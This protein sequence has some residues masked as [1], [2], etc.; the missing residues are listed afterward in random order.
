MRSVALLGRPGAALLTCTV[1]ITTVL[2]LA[3]GGVASAAVRAAPADVAPGAPGAPSYFDLARKDCVGTATGTRSRV[4]YTVA[5]GVLSDV[6]EPTI[7][8]TDVSTLQY[9]VTDGATFTDLQA[10]DMTYT[11]A[12]D[13]TGMACT[14][15]ATDAGHGFR[16]ITTYITDPARDTV[17]MRTRLAALRGSGTNLADLHLYARLDAHV[18]GN[19]GGGSQNAGGN[20]GGIDTSTGSPVP[21]ISSTNTVTNAVNRDYAV[22]TFMALDASVSSPA[23]SVGY[24]GSASDGLTQL[25][26]DRAL[27]PYDSAPDGHVTAT[28]EVTPGRGHSVT[29]AL[30]FGRDQASAVATARRSL[31]QPFATAELNYLHGWLGYDAGLR[32]PFGD[33]GAAAWRD[34]GAI[35]HY[36]LS[37]NVIKA[38][39]DKTYPGAIVASL[40]SPWGQSVPAGNF[41][42]G[43][44]GYFGSYREVFARDLYEAFTGLLVDGDLVTARAATRFLFDRQQQ[45]D[46]SMPRNSLLNGKTAPDTGG[47]QLDET[48]YPIVMALQAGLGGNGALWRDHIRPAADFLVAHGPS[49]GVERW[50]EQS[51]YSPSTIAAEI[52]GL[53]AASVIAGEHHD[54]ARARVYQATADYFQRTVKSWTVTTSGPYA[55]SYFIRLSKTGDPNAAIRYNLGNGGPALDQRAVVDG[56]FQELVR[57][58]ELPVSDPDVQASLGVWDKQIAVSTP[59]GTG[60]YRYGNSAA[61]GSADG[62]GDCYQPSQT[63]C[64][65]VGAPWAPTGIGTG[66]LWPVLSGERA[67]SDVAGHNRSGAAS[68]LTAI[69][70]FSSGE[71]LVPEQAWENPD[72]PASPYGSD[73]LT[74]S[75]GFTDGKAAGSASPLTWAQA[76]ELRLI[77]A[78]ATGRNPETPQFTARRYV[79]HGP[80]GAL[81]VTI[82]APAN[83]STLAATS[84]TVTG[85]TAARA[86]VTVSSV[87]A[88][89]GASSVASTTA[90]ADG[91]FSATVPIG[92]GSN[93]IT[94]GASTHGLRNTGYAQVTVS[95][96]GGGTTVLDVSDPSGDDNGPGTYQYPTS[97]DFQPGAFDLTR[98]QVL[99]DGTTAYLRAT[100]ANLA[101]T[102][103]V[104]GG[105]QLL[106]V[107]V[108]TPG[109]ATTSTAA[110]FPTRNYTI[111]SPGAWSQRLE[112]Q[113]FASPV[114]QDASG[115]SVG[116]P[117]VLMSQ[118]DGTITIALPES[119]FGTPGSGW[120]F[121][122]VL[123]GQDGFSP[124]QARGF[125]PAAQ[126]FLFGVCAPNGTA[127]V[128][129]ADPGTVPKAVDVITPQGVSQATELDPT[130]GPVIIQPVTVP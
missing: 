5:G 102:F 34:R 118:S 9:I 50:E 10:R 117:Q 85:T 71:G 40:A 43:A 24:A 41:A 14:V 16:L 92:F 33:S 30:G 119:Q 75:I 111:A 122:V 81:S 32:P 74:A 82:T 12:A 98:F 60:Y 101:A 99:S 105:A 48:S 4:W 83:G 72:L 18:N 35:L 2:A 124:D 110:A 26:L 112:V 47:T 103:G 107:Y 57:L 95:N 113:G 87:D 8:N 125:A 27:T 104:V 11:V 79:A 37:A 38:S 90:A 91:S 78:L 3:T 51:G 73:P 52:A 66:H 100:V 77:L 19:G 28:E 108:H 84:T 68:L 36:Y 128:C 23:A 129:S 120:G 39:V 59:S 80:P 69:E 114:W 56:G 127:P 42:N 61:Q 46:G 76:Q 20:T 13:P 88:T 21:V 106:D 116:T 31:R 58:G 130:L 67:E 89:S 17:L 63:T 115:N 109:A 55:P 96:E 64:P 126:A 22:P 94:V 121:T 45:A 1:A 6:Y 65:T 7:D 44:P 62:Y 123:T 86:K 15:T 93:A 97:G 53:T 54:P 29:L 70:N 49:F 25:D